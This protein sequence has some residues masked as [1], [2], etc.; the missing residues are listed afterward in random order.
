MSTAATLPREIILA[1]PSAA[2]FQQAIALALKGYTF[3]NWQMDQAFPNIAGSVLNMV[4]GQP[5]ASAIEAAEEA[6]ARALALEQDQAAFL[7]LEAT[8][9]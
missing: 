9:V 2:V 1:G 3:A 7:K 8:A 5:D 4:R 6:M